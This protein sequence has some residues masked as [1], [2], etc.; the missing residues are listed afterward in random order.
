MSG[1]EFIFA[2]VT[3]YNSSQKIPQGQNLNMMAIIVKMRLMLFALMVSTVYCKIYDR[4]EFA[5]ELKNKHGISG[6]ELEKWVCI[7]KYE[8]N[9]D[10]AAVNYYSNDHGIFQI[11][12]LFWC[13]KNGNERKACHINCDD[14]EDDDITDDLK[15]AKKIH[16]AHK[17]LSGDGFK[18]WVVYEIYCKGSQSNGYLNGCETTTTPETSSQYTQ[19]DMPPG[20]DQEDILSLELTDEELLDMTAKR[21][22]AWTMSKAKLIT[23]PAEGVTDTCQ[24]IDIIKSKRAMAEGKKPGMIAVDT[25][26]IMDDEYDTQ[27]NKTSETP[28]LMVEQKKTEEDRTR[29]RSAFARRSTP[30]VEGSKVVVVRSQG[31]SY[32]DLL[33]TVKDKI[34]KDEAGEILS[35]RKSRNED[36]EV[37]IKDAKDAA[38]FTATLRDRASDLQVDF[39]TK[40]DRRAVVHVK[41]MEESITAQE[42]SEAIMAVIGDT[43]SFRITSLRQAYGNTRNATKSVAYF[44]LPSAIRPIPHSEELH[45]PTP[46]E[47]WSLKESVDN[48][49][50]YGDLEIYERCQLARELLFKYNIPLIEVPIWVCIAKHESAYDTNASNQSFYGIFQL[51][52]KYWCNITPKSNNVCGTSCS[53]FL[54]DDISDDINCA[55]IIHD[56]YLTVYGKNPFSSWIAYKKICSKDKRI[57]RYADDCF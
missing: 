20:A 1:P 38:Q 40:G 24:F 2:S 23:L 45:V 43:E 32:A 49:E 25:S 8:S 53:K 16:K 35:L 42:L 55:K 39:R 14:L 27:T 18:A 26:V 52:G 37:K 9:F 33:G 44:S 12:E 19:I 17:R 22:S 3:G 30:V 13:N 7:A 56:E 36:L 41:D 34:F 51:S 28:G 6:D 29:S 15:C 50:D 5:E 57:F 11:S 4:C 10:T 54:D 47:T 31:K 46:P 48:E 21:W